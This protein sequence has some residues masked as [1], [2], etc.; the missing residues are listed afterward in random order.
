M[1]HVVKGILR[2]NILFAIIT[3]TFHINIV[4]PNTLGLYPRAPLFR[5]EVQGMIQVSYYYNYELVSLCTLFQHST[6]SI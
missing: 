1:L 3:D 4:I 6:K 5:N 2:A